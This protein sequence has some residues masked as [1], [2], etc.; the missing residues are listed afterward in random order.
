MILCTFSGVRIYNLSAKFLCFFFRSEDFLTLCLW[1]CFLAS[2]ILKESIETVFAS[3]N[4]WTSAQCSFLGNQRRLTAFSCLLLLFDS[5]VLWSVSIFFLWP[6]RY[7]CSSRSS[8]IVSHSVW[9]FAHLYV[10]LF[11]INFCPWQGNADVCYL[12]KL[13]SIT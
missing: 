3:V 8:T 1:F 4:T 7:L 11:F 9:P 13:C 5:L 6:K 10:C 2:C 12:K